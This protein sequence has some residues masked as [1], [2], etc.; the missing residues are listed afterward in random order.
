LLPTLQ[1][2]KVDVVLVL[3]HDKLTADLN[4][5][6]TGQG[7]TIVKLPRCLSS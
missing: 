4:G 1:A 5:L 3:G 2:F 6:L 7:V